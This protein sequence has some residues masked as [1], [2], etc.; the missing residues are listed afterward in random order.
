MIS[1]HTPHTR[2]DINSFLFFH[3]L[4]DFYSHTSY[5]VRLDTLRLCLF[6]QV[7]LLTHL[8]R[9]A[10]LCLLL[11]NFLMLIST[12]TP[13]TRCDQRGR[14]IYTNYNNFYSHTSYEVRLNANTLYVIEDIFLLTHLIRG[15][16]SL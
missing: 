12:H 3:I 11:H 2:C 7:F 4:S 5:E 6:F 13:H 10:T 15:A 16:T 8:I 1:T 14:R 9:G